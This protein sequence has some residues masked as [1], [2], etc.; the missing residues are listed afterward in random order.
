MREIRFIHCADL[1]IDSP[2][3]GLS[4]VHPDLSG[5]LYQSTYQAFNNIIELAIREKVDCVLFCGDIYDGADKSLQAQLRFRDGLQRLSNADIQS[6]VIHGNH[7]PLDSWF[8]TL[9]WPEKVTIFGG[10]EAKR[11]SLI[12]EGEVVAYIYGISFPK[13]Q[14]YDNLALKF[15]RED[16][17]IPS[18]GLLHTNVGENTGHEPYAP[19]TV[20]DLSSKGMIYWALGHVHNH[21][22]L[23]SSNP[24]IVY[25]GNSQGRNPREAGAKGCCLVTLYP[26]GD[27]NLQFV[28]CDVVRY[29]T[30]NLDISSCNNVDDVID[31]IKEKCEEIADK[32]DGRHAVILLSLTGRTVLHLELLKGNNLEDL[33]VRTRECFEGRNP[34]IWLGK[35]K[36][37][38]AGTYDLEMLRKGNN[39]ISDIIS[40]YDELEDVESPHWEPIR[41]ALEPLFSTWQGQRHLEEL[42]TEEILE[43][44]NEA[45]SLT[46]DKLIKS[47]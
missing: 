42:S 13:R 28:P 31:S 33:L 7:D 30:A 14:I 15:V 6:F 40:L 47:E 34:W 29:N 21:K 11:V 3:R 45:K 25:S 36:L 38:T 27:C 17:E 26:D 2:F 37:K 8:A 35:L 4:E 10:D 9:K 43:I 23:K 5:I 32:M 44:V 18:I 12:K 41:K 1:H 19:A 39:F 22:I 24:T 46:L 16:Y 20:E